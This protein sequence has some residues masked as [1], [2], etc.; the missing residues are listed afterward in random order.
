LGLLALV[1]VP[2]ACQLQSPG[3]VNNIW[4]WCAAID[5]LLLAYGARMMI[6]RRHSLPSDRAPL[7]M[8]LAIVLVVAVYL[9]YFWH[10]EDQFDYWAHQG[11]RYSTK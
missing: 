3:S 1:F 5:L 4:W 8:L 10:A 11:I 2:A 6:V 7:Y 9:G